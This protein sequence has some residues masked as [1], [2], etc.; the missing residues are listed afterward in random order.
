MPSFPSLQL[1]EDLVDVA[2][3]QD[4]YAIDSMIHTPLF[5]PKKTR[6]E[7]LL[8]LVSKGAGFVALPPIW[9]MGLVLQEVVRFAVGEAFEKDNSATRELQTVLW[10]RSQSASFTFRRLKDR[11]RYVRKRCFTSY[12][13]S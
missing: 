8:A 13:W 3:L 1:L 6:T 7:L 2:L 5:E 12:Q 4:S 9:R 10:K 11:L